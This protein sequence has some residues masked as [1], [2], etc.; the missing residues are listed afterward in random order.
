MTSGTAAN[1]DLR[2]VTPL[3]SGSY[4][5]R[6]EH[7]GSVLGGVE[8]TVEAAAALRDAIKRQI[9]DEDLVPARGRTIAEFGREFLASR[10]GNR[11]SKND[12]GRWQQHIVSSSLG[13]RVPS[14]V[15]VKDIVN[16]L[17][18]LQTKR[19]NYDSK[20]H[21]KRETK[22]LSRQT[23]KHAL[24]LLRRFFV[25]AIEQ[26]HAMN[27]P[28]VGLQVARRDGDEG[29]GYQEGWYLDATDQARVHQLLKDDPERWIV[30]FAI[31]TGLRQ[32]EQW[33]LHLEDVHVDGNDP[34]VLVRFGSWDARKKRYRPPKGRAGEKKTRRVPLFGLGLEAATEWL[35]VLPTYAPHNPL[36]LMFPTPA[37]LKGGEDGQRDYR[38]GARRM[39]KAPGSWSKVVAELEVPRLGRKPWWHLLRHT[40]ASSLV[41]GWWGQRWRLEDVRMVLGHSS[42]KVT[43]RYAHLVPNVVQGVANAAQAAWESR[44][45]AVTTFSADPKKASNI[46]GTPGRT[47]T[48]DPRLRR[49]LLY[50]AELRARTIHKLR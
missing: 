21:G 12:G 23:R 6:I 45:G 29:E 48:C 42:V 1:L 11:S 38:G 30:A 25:W 26:E 15:T 50:P 34:H 5:V 49:P 47:R 7:G 2:N 32:G 10:S 19:T 16:W 27:N 13:K 9:A 18:A 4:R 33:C 31:G 24:N 46:A 39:G 17:A 22:L 43:E 37:I 14:T 20:K 35:N 41:S 36:G 44:H 3:P 28:C 40:C 8:A